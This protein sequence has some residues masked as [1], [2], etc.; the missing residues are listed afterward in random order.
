MFW[1]SEGN[2]LVKQMTEL[3]EEVRALGLMNWPKWQ[4]EHG[5]YVKMDKAMEETA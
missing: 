1:V 4:A 3:I 5:Y 2:L